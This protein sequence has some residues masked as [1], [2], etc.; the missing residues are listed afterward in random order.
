MN[1]LVPLT[2]S[3]L[4]AIALAL[5]PLALLWWWQQKAEKDWFLL[6]GSGVPIGIQVRCMGKAHPDAQLIKAISVACNF[7]DLTHAWPMGFV[8]LAVANT[9][10]TVMDRTQWTFYWKTH[11]LN[12]VLSRRHIVVDRQL[13]SLAHELAHLCEYFLEGGNVDPAHRNWALRGIAYACMEYEVWAA[14]EIPK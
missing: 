4:V 7:L 8:H 11:E 9:K 13:G 1:P 2:L 5:I 3:T 14:K 6:L 10:I 12:E